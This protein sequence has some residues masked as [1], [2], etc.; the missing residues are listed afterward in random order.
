MHVQEFAGSKAEAL[1]DA[2]VAY[3][4]TRLQGDALER[5]YERRV[6]WLLA[7]AARL[8]LGDV[9]SEASIKQ[10][11]IDY[12]AD[13]KLGGGIPVLVGDIA[14]A[15]YEHPV[16]EHT[17]LAELLPDREFEELLDKLLEMQRL[18][19]EIIHH[20]VSTPVFANLVAQ[21]LYSGLRGYLAHG[22][23]VAR[24]VPGAGMAMKAGRALL[25]RAPSRLSAAIERGIRDYVERYTR[26]GIQLSEAYLRAAF[27]SDEL[28]Q[29]VLDFWDDH[30]HRSVASVR[31]VAGQLD[32]EELFV[33]GYEYWQRL[34]RTPI[35][36]ELIEN[37]VEVFFDS[38]RDVTLADLL[39]DI[40]VT[41]EMIVRDGM[42]F[43][44]QV[45]EALQARGMLEPAIRRHLEDFYRSDA[46]ARILRDPA[47]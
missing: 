20:S 1:L 4:A 46:V 24:R 36:R 43:V 15:I 25:D 9:V 41:R 42:R 28:R 22:Q 44:P 26:S 5:E 10:T 11:A 35:Y 31:D 8:R 3:L 2:H 38:Y 47:G 17:T 13:M 14:A 33:I 27:E 16:H 12:A 39:A 18:R 7:D 30:K 19:E 6:D 23:R 32:I 45:V 37:G 34:R 29:A 21:L 40:G